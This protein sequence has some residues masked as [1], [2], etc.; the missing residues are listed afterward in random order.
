MHRR[1]ADP[2]SR[3]HGRRKISLGV[4]GAVAVLLVLAGC[5]RGADKQTAGEKVDAAIAKTQQ[6]GVELADDAARAVDKASDAVVRT[7]KDIAITADV[8]AS[9]ARDESL[10]ALSINVDTTAGRVVLKGDAPDAAARERATQIAK[11]VDGVASVDN[12]LQIKTV[13]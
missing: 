6:K 9:L 11:A 8:N 3:D 13:N 10:S 7:S 1:N 12:R 2:H 4:V 5:D